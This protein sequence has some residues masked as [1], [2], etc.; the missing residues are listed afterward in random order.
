[1]LDRSEVCGAL[2]LDDD[3]PL[4]QNLFFLLSRNILTPDDHDI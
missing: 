2:A 3:I 4:N 1:M